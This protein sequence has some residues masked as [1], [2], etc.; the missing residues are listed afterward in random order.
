MFNFDL[1]IVGK[2]AVHAPSTKRMMLSLLACLYDPLGYYSPVTV[3][4]KILF[5]QLCTAK[6]S[7]DD[8]LDG[9]ATEKWDKWVEDLNKAKE[10]K[11]QRCVYEKSDLHVTECFLDGFGDVSKAAY[12]AV[13]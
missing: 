8:E 1:T 2:R 5:Q 11:I 4:V 12:S 10:I 9:Q 6:L 3:S 13:I 7:W